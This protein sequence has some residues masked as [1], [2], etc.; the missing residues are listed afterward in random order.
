MSKL[1]INVFN[2]FIMVIIAFVIIGFIITFALFCC[3]N[4]DFVFGFIM[5]LLLLNLVQYLRDNYKNK[6]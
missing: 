2:Y 3:G 5:G 4:A 1:L 6:M